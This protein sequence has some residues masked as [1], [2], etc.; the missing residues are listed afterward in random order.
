M[1]TC[2]HVPNAA[3][4]SRA[5]VTP[6]DR[7]DSSPNA[8]DAYASWPT[9]YAATRLDQPIDG[10][11]DARDQI[12]APAIA[13]ASVSHSNTLGTGRNRR[14]SRSRKYGCDRNRRVK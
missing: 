2:S 7:F 5:P 1:T 13:T 14:T 6:P 12:V 3:Y 9:K 8:H 4:Q 10:A 11:S